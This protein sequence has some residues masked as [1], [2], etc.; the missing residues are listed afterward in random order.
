MTWNGTTLVG[1]KLKFTDLDITN[2]SI[3]N[4]NISSLNILIILFQKI[5]Y[6]ILILRLIVIPVI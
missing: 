1:N 6:Y 4:L 5:K 2:G 3:D